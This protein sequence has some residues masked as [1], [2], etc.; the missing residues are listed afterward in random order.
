MHVKPDNM[1]QAEEGKSKA[2]MDVT[3]GEHNLESYCPFPLSPYPKPCTVELH[4][5]IHFGKSQTLLI[6]K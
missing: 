1:R 6:V 3:L 5:G 4:R 2:N